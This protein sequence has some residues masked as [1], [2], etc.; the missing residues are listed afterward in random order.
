MAKLITSYGELRERGHW[1]PYCVKCGAPATRTTYAVFKGMW[2]KLSGSRLW[3]K[4]D[5]EVGLR[6]KLPVCEKHPLFGH[7]DLIIALGCTVGFV[8]V[9]IGMLF[10]YLHL[11]DTPILVSLAFV[12]FAGIVLFL[13]SKV[14]TLPGTRFS[15]DEIALKDVSPTFVDAWEEREWSREEFRAALR[16]NRK[17]AGRSAPPF[18]L[19]PGFFIPVDS[20]R[21]ALPSSTSSW[22]GGMSTPA[23]AR[24]G[25][26]PGY[27][28]PSSGKRR[29][30]TGA[31]TTWCSVAPGIPSISL[32]MASSRTVNPAAW[33][34]G[35][36]PPISVPWVRSC[37]GSS[38]SIP[39]VIPT[40]R[41]GWTNSASSTGP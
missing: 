11:P 26:K 21:T 30:T 15:E 7:S 31:G 17:A 38:G 36:S 35:P 41:A 24:M 9:L 18:W 34:V 40:S 25:T 20:V 33:P 4:V 8:Y 19:H 6:L 22:T 28:S 29:S 13:L 12:A 1:P 14:T 5:E 27:P 2:S 37:A 16:R 32:S 23:F 39:G 3:N 10:H